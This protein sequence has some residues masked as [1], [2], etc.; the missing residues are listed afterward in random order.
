MHGHAGQLARGSHEHRARH[1]HRGLISN[2][3]PCK[4]SL[5]NNAADPI[6]QSV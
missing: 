2:G 6:G 5:A 4:S 3:A 1:E